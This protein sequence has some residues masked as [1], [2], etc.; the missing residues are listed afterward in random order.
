VKIGSDSTKPIILM[1]A[2]ANPSE[3]YS[4]FMAHYLIN[5]LVQRDIVVQKLRDNY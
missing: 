4:S 2:R 1:V 3:T 5:V